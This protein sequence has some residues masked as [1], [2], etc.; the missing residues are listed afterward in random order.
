MCHMHRNIQWK[1][2][3]TRSLNTQITNTEQLNKNMKDTVD[4]FACV[5]TK[6]TLR[7]VSQREDV[8][9]WVKEA[10]LQDL[11]SVRI[12]RS[13]ADSHKDTSIPP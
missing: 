8:W 3:L 12:C 10:H 9:A 2:L 13:L 1:T 6:H 7:K 5:K 4:L 11:S